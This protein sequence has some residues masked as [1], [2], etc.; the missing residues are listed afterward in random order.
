MTT[1]FGVFQSQFLNAV[2]AVSSDTNWG[3]EF[4]LVIDRAE[5]RCYRDLDMFAVR[6][7][8]QMINGFSPFNRTQVIPAVPFSSVVSIIGAGFGTSIPISIDAINV[9]TFT[10]TMTVSSTGSRQNLIRSSPTFID[11]C[12]PSDGAITGVPQYYAQISDQLIMVG[13]PP[14]NS[15]LWEIR[16]PVRPLP[17]S[18]ANSSTPLTINYPD[19]FF[20]SAMI[21]AGMFMRFVEPAMSATWMTEY[22]DIMKSATVEEMR[23]RNMAE[24]WLSYQPS[25]IATPPRQ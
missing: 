16:G 15:F 9:L 7:W 10:S 2:A 17:L 11:L 23:K 24:G 1:N 20:A 19:V 25:P 22:K 13:P 6:Q 3:T 5:Q 14:V 8:T 21:E 18:S 4:P 12:W